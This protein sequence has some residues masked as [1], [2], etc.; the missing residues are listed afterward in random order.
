MP[1][2]AYQWLGEVGDYSEALAG[3]ERSL[4]F[5]VSGMGF[6]VPT[7]EDYES[8]FRVQGLL[9]EETDIRETP[10]LVAAAQAHWHSDGN[11]GCVFASQMSSA[12]E[13]N[14]WETYVLSDNGGARED[15]DALHALWSSRV[16]APEAEVVSVLL[17]HN[18]EPDYLAALLRR[19]RDLPSW[20][21]TDE[22]DETDDEV[23]DLQRLGVRVTV[24]FNY[25]S[26][27]LGFGRY[28]GFG[29]TRR[30]PFTE[31]AI[32]GKPPRK[33]RRDLRAFMAQVDIPGLDGED[34][35]LWWDQ[36]KANRAARLGARHNER[37]KARVT[38]ALPHEV[39]GGE[40]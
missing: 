17:P 8:A 20:S 19:L 1:T 40:L 33:R 21:V 23:G 3:L 4:R 24:E 38:F 35:G 34:F 12:R 15:A 14:G 29:N 27:V 37:A 32:R 25:E 13:L 2:D 6:A 7:R 22:G 36:T 31:L 26:E 11:N 39:W 30:T 9:G 18:D 5:D 10:E 28:N 16:A